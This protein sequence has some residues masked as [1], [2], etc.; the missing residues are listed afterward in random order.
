MAIAAGI[1]KG[2]RTHNHGQSMTLHSLRMTNAT[3]RS[4]AMVIP[5][6]VEEEEEELS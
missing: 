6:E 2:D 5:L 1:Q 3:P 4:P